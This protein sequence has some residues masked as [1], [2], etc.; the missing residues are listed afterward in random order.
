MRVILISGKAQHGKDTTARILKDELELHGD[1]VLIAHYAD[2]V[3]YI[4]R[5]F[6]GWDGN[7]DEYG[8][9][10]LQYVGTDVI[11]QEDP[12][13]WVDFLSDILHFF[14]D[15]WDVVIIPDARFPNE[16][17]RMRDN[18]HQL[19]H[20]RVVRD[21]FNSPLTDEQQHHA[22]EVALDDVTPDVLFKN[23][24]SLDDLA[25]TIQA[26]IKENIYE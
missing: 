12:N 1:N 22:S 9:H 4:C 10:L 13:Y 18:G 17:E 5:T 23:N 16:I 8:R 6:F 21:K 15:E 2:L 7:K 24:G 25:A 26:W 11:R 19:T 14:P 3:K 20:I